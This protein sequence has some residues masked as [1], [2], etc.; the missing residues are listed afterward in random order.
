MS[1]SFL[2]STLCS[3]FSNEKPIY[4]REQTSRAYPPWLYVVAKMTSEQPPQVLPPLC[5]FT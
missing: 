4:L 5:F 2:N 3:A 1:T